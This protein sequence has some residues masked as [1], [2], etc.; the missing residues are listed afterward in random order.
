MSQNRRFRIWALVIIVIFIYWL[1]R[2]GTGLYT[3]LL[4]FQH[5]QLESVYWTTFWARVGVGLIVAVPFAILF[6]VNAFVARWLSIRSV[7]FFS[8]ETLVA[9]KFLIWAIA[10]VGL[11]L[12][13]LV[14]T[15][16]S[17]S[18]LLFLRYFNQHP[19]N[20]ADPI[21]NMD[22][23]FYLF[24]LPV[25]HF[26]QTWLVIALFLSLI[27]A[28]AVYA[29]AQ[30]NNLAEG[31][32]VILPHVQLHLSILGAIIFLTF[33]LGHWLNLFDLM[34]SPRGVA[35]GASY[36]DI[37]VSMPALWVM[38]IVAVA[39]AAILL[40]N[41]YLRRPALSLLAIFIWIIVGIVGTG[42]VPS[43]VQRYAVEPNE[44]AREAPYIQ[45]NIKFTNIAYG[46]DKITELNFPALEPLTLE[47][48]ANDASVL[49]NC[50]IIDRS[51]RPT[52]RS[53]QS[54]FTTFFPTSTLT[55]IWS[56]VNCVRW[57]WPAGNWIKVSFNR[58][59]GSPKSCNLPTVTARL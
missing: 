44:L 10:G 43:F 1:I 51:N 4:W 38:V 56:M 20:L 29:V 24:S 45:N 8:E 9:Q 32:V 17:N 48:L 37:N 27:G 49:D 39:T 35:F 42:F 7:L 15:A 59:P 54:A 3:D 19:F 12:G 2:F 34:Y 11:M 5:L 13:W 30:Q 47:K 21:F 6:W 33:A 26:I 46:L 22:V 36:T 55:A 50:G 53:R 18:W 57:R 16:A 23:G 40:A 28:V 41:I 25:F 52:S 14:G 58:P 31:K